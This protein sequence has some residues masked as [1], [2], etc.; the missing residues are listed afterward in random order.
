MP[1]MDKTGPF[2]NGPMGK[3]LGPCG[4]GQGGRGKGRGFRRGGGAGWERVSA[5]LPPD[6]EKVV[7]EHQKIILETQ[8]AAIIQKLQGLDQNKENK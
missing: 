4:G 3:G 6:E 7:L 2:G 1:G 5:M 8:L